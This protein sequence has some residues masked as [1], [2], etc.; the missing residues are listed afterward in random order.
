MTTPNTNLTAGAALAAAAE[1]QQARVE[2]VA[3]VKLTPAA[4]AKFCASAARLTNPDANGLIPL[5]QMSHDER[6]QLAARLDDFRDRITDTKHPMHTRI[7]NF[8]KNR[9]GLV[10]ITLTAINVTRKKISDLDELIP[11]RELAPDGTEVIDEI[12]GQYDG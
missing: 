9:R 7:A 1:A 4:V 8:A 12:L 11:P 5:A 10:R 3:A 6:V 2:P